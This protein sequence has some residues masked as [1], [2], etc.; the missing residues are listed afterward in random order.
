MPKPPSLGHPT[1][2]PLSDDCRVL[3]DAAPDAMLIVNG[4]GEIVIANPTAERLFG[5]SAAEFEGRAVESLIP[6]RLREQHELHRANYMSHPQARP[7]GAALELLAQRSDGTEVPVDISLSPLNTD[8]GAFV[9]LAIRD[10]TGRRRTE[11]GLRKSEREYRA[12][13]ENANDSIMIFELESETILDANPKACEIYGFT[14]DEFIGMSLKS[15]TVDVPRGEEGLRQLLQT[16]SCRDYHTV[17]IRKD[18]T[19]MSIVANSALLER[20]GR[21]VVLSIDRD[22]TERIRAQAER[23]QLIE[24]LTAALAKI[25]TLTGLLPICASCKNIR[26]EA[27]NWTAVERYVRDRSEANFTHSIC[28]ECAQRLYPDDYKKKT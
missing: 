13:F 5:Y 14:R 16:G 24:E 22:D 3:L 8:H 23:E 6:G 27:G 7:M 4:D 18:G 2:P 12:L 9:L 21:K 17:H 1:A 15:L 10:V 20:N 11:E 26:D 28:P 19:P 25:K